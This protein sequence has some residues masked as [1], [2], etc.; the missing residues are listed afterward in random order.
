VRIRVHRNDSVMPDVR[1]HLA[2]RPD[3]TFDV[4]GLRRE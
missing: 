4:I 2:Y 3:R 1:V